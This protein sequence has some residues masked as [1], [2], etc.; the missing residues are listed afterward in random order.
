MVQVFLP[1]RLLERLVGAAAGKPAADLAEVARKM[2]LASL[3]LAEKADTALHGRLNSGFGE[4]RSPLPF[5]FAIRSGCLQQRVARTA[6]V[7][8]NWNSG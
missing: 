2:I 5:R 4:G 3:K 6:Y 1:E 7:N 8:T